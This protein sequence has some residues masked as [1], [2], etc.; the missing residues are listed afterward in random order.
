MSK[1]NLTITPQRI[2][3]LF[4]L[5]ALLFP[6]HQA[7]AAFHDDDKAVVVTRAEV[8]FNTNQ[9]TITG[10]NFGTKP[11]T[12]KLE[13]TTLVLVRSS[14]TQI[15][16]LWPAGIKAGTYLLTIKMSKNGRIDN[17]VKCDEDDNCK[18]F[19]I[20]IGAVGPQGPAG[21]KGDKG[22]TGATG[23]QG[24]P[25]QSVTTIS[26]PP[27][28][29]CTNGGLMLTDSSGN[30]F[31][32]NGAPGAKGDKGDPGNSGAAPIVTAEAAGANCASGGLK[33]TDASGA[34]NYVCNGAS[35][36]SGGSNLFITQ[37]KFFGVPPDADSTQLGVLNLPP[38]NY[39]VYAKATARS[40]STYSPHL[41]CQFRVNNAFDI[42][43]NADMDVPVKSDA[44][45]GLTQAYSL[46][47]G[48]PVQLMCTQQTP[49][50]PQTGQP[51]F[52]PRSIVIIR[53]VFWATPVSTITVQ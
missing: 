3:P 50:N 14:Q 1:N 25:G 6:L 20:T 22:E 23:Q 12:V 21:L 41:S 4:L 49:I 17:S 9:L 32:C 46:P 2:V 7:S 27:G 43:S 40:S 5:L 37:A 8:D 24:S 36:T 10:R 26:V 47:A 11:P 53:I 16:A 44:P 33:V 42:D 39:L 31:I 45:F 19:D 13:D 30:H 34:V 51:L 28:A 52:T 18:T 15:V 48:G 29:N 38:G 35:G